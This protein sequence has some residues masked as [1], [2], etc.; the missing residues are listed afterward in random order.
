M[1]RAFVLALLVALLGG[2]AIREAGESKKDLSGAPFSPGEKLTF[3]VIYLAL[4]AGTIVLKVEE[5]ISWEGYEVYRLVATARSSPLFS[6]FYRVRN[7]LESLIDVKTL[8]PRRFEE[9]REEGRHR[10][11]EIVLFDR[12]RKVAVAFDVKEG[13]TAAE[14]VRIP[15]PADVQ[16]ALSAFYHLRR[17]ELK[18]G[19]IVVIDVNTG[20][21]N[22]QVEVEV[23]GREK[24]G[25][26]ELETIV[27]KPTLK[28]AKLGGILEE[29]DDVYI[30]LT[31]DER[32]I[33]VRIVA[34]V[35]FGSLII[36]LV[37]KE[38]RE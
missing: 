9:H 34:E 5:M 10:N 23:L 16:D 4:P 28:K 38:L 18:V 36:I 21:K 1:K 12:D 19:E 29:K 24:L 31:D 7:R 2:G 27:V 30:W 15:V 13:E 25:K 20:D 22:Y 6:L 32:R 11:H 3:R 33:P 26:Q 14:G 37:D 8:L 17:Q 35:G